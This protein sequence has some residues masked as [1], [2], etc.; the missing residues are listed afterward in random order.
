MNA[1][2]KLYLREMQWLEDDFADS[3]DFELIG[4]SSHLPPQRLCWELNRT[5]GWSLQFSHLLDIAQKKGNSSHA[6]YRFNESG[7]AGQSAFHVV[8]NK[9]PEGIIARFQG[10]A[11]LDYLV[12]LSEGCEQAAELIPRLRKVKGV[13]YVQILDPLNSGAIEHLALIDLVDSAK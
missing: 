11:A 2:L 12:H 7:D 13:N 9:L 3:C 10:A 4:L 5:V 8:E 6:V 1:N